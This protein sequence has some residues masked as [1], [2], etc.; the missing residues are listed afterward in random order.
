M[1]STKLEEEVMFLIEAKKKARENGKEG[2][3]ANRLKVLFL[4]GQVS[5]E[6]YKI[7]C[8]MC[9]VKAAEPPTKIVYR[10]TSTNGRC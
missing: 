6:A 4:E 10:D 7:M 2:D 8:Q 3:F 1:A 5:E 9:G